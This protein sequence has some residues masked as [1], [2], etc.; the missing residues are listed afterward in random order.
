MA[1]KITKL[2]RQ[3]QRKYMQYIPQMKGCH[4]SNTQRTFENQEVK[5]QIPERNMSKKPRHCREKY[6]RMVLKHIKTACILNKRNT[7]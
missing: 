3:T 4:F 1:K 7:K 6:A 5:V 2:K